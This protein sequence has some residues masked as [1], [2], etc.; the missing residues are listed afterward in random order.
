VFYAGLGPGSVSRA[1]EVTLLPLSSG[2]V[3]KRPRF[4]HVSS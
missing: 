2:R 3:F 1:S 4:R